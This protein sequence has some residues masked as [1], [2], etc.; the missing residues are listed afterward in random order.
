MKQ[1]IFILFF[2]CFNFTYSQEQNCELEATIFKF[3][4]NE[5]NGCPGWYLSVNTDT[6]KVLGIDANLNP[7]RL[8]FPVKAYVTMGEK[9]DEFSIDFPYYQLDCITIPCFDQEI[10]DNHNGLCL[11]NLD[12]VCGCDGQTYGNFCEAKKNGIN[13]AQQGSCED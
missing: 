12:P 10:K 11:L 1:V 13:L 5:C 9:A 8:K 3:T 4:G 6:F 7:M 2:L